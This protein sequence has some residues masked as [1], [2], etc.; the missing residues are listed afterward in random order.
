[1]IINLE[2]AMS[3]LQALPVFIWTEYQTTAWRQ[4]LS[5]NEYF[6]LTTQKLTAPRK[7]RKFQ[8]IFLQRLYTN[9]EGHA[10]ELY[11]LLVQALVVTGHTTIV[12]LLQNG[13]APP[14]LMAGQTENE[15]IVNWNKLVGAGPRL[16]SADASG[17]FKGE[18]LGH[19]H[20]Y[21]K[22]PFFQR[23]TNAQGQA[24]RMAIWLHCF[25]QT[26]ESDLT[27]AW[28]LFNSLLYF[29]HAWD[30]ELYHQLK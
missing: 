15:T 16:C 7:M 10:I 8:S 30:S 28:K 3:A 20:A 18:M 6:L 23:L 11:Q 27:I 13:P 19:W 25:H 12:I 5:A 17:L 29:V 21:M 2:M 4:C 24:E 22:T 14:L 1:M 26:C 9:D